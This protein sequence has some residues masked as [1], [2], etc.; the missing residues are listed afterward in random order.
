MR[1]LDI[2]LNFAFPS[3]LGETMAAVPAN[4]QKQQDKKPQVIFVLG[5]PGSGKGT[6]CGKL[7]AEFGVIHLSAGDLL[8]AERNSGSA[9]ADEINTHIKN[10]TIV[11]VEITVGLIKKAMQAEMKKGN[12]LF[13]IDGFPRNEDNY[14]GW[15]K[16]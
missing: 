8:R 9:V 3:L 16:V 15:N 10:G 6:Q 2:E 13:V 11:P 12:Y 14:S 1:F 4:E 5:G 7:V